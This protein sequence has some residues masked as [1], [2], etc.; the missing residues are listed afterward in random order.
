MQVLDGVQA[1]LASAGGTHTQATAEL[2]RG[3][4]QA[5][6]KL[7]CASS[8]LEMLDLLLRCTPA[9]NGELM[10]LLPAHV[11][12]MDLSAPAPR[13]AGLVS[14]LVHLPGPVVTPR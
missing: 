5:S 14:L 10:L 9:D 3:L 2:A 7:R 4:E 8:A 11:L 6:A 13:P 1:R 12:V